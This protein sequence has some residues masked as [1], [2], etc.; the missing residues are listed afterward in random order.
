[1]VKLTLW[2]QLFFLNERNQLKQR[3]FALKVKEDNTYTLNRIAM[4]NHNVT[5]KNF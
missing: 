4:V 2:S 1:M 5:L 3:D